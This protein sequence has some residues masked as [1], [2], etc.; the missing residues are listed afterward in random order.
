VRLTKIVC[1]VAALAYMLLRVGPI[2]GQG[3]YF[4]IATTVLA[5][6]VWGFISILDELASY[7]WNKRKKD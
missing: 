4:W 7:A 2:T 3:E 1:V 5:L 6:A